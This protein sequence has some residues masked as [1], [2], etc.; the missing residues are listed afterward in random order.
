MWLEHWHNSGVTLAA[1][2]PALVADE[3]KGI[4]APNL[5]RELATPNHFDHSLA[6]LCPSSHTRKS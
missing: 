3:H 4:P 6:H 5:A 2:E 1:R